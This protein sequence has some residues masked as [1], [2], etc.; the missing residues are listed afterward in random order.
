MLEPG[1]AQCGDGTRRGELFAA[2]N[3]AQGNDAIRARP[4][5]LL[6][7]HRLDERGYLR[8]WR[9]WRRLADARLRARLAARQRRQH[10]ARQD[11]TAPEV[12]PDKYEGTQPQKYPAQVPHGEPG[13]I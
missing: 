4:C 6:F 9:R 3:E 1:V 7:R 12:H 10:V 11:A 8:S 5:L 13:Y 2:R